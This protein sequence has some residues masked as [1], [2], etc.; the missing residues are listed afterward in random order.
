MYLVYFRDYLLVTIPPPTHT[1][2]IA[3]TVPTSKLS[4]LST[5]NLIYTQVPHFKGDIIKCKKPCSPDF[6]LVKRQ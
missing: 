2:S 3:V 5:G 6:W 1:P 4:L